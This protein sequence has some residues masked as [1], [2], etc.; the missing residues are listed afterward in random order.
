MLLTVSSLY[1]GITF[2]YTILP[3]VLVANC[4]AAELLGMVQETLPDC[5][6]CHHIQEDL[7]LRFDWAHLS[8]DISYISGIRGGRPADVPMLHLLL[9][10]EETIILLLTTAWP[11]SI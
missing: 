10:H 4:N 6:R 11:S 8:A 9:C 1:S 2:G 7:Q 5:P 3:T